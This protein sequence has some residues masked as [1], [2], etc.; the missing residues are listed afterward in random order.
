MSDT[1]N[2][3]DL[4]DPQVQE[5]WY[6][7]YDRLR[8]EA[9][10]CYMPEANMYVVS[11]YEDIHYI[12]RNPEIFTTQEGQL[13][14]DPLLPDADA[15]KIYKE[16]GFDRMFP[17]SCD[18][19]LHRCY[20]SLVEDAFS[21]NGIRKYE[22]FI[23]QRVDELIDQWIEKGEVEFISAFCDPLPQSVIAT[24]LGFPLEDLP[25]LADWSAAWVLPWSGELTKDTQLMVAQKGVEFQNY[26]VQAVRERRANPKDDLISHLANATYNNE[27]PLTE[28]EVISMIDHLFIGGNETT[29]FAIASGLWLLINNPL[30][31][32]Q[33]RGDRSLIKNMVEEILRMESPTQGM[34]RI[35][36]QETQLSGVTIPK[37][38]TVQL[39]FGAANRDPE[40][41]A[42]PAQM[43]VSRKNAGSH[44]AFSQATHSC[45]GAN[46]SRVEMVI[47]FE[48]LLGRLDDIQFA[49]AKN[50][51]S[52]MP[53][54]VLRA[55]NQ[56]HITFTTQHD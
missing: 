28:T 29:T 50:D 3:I 8:E 38:A 12:V 35:T 48:H 11:R 53:G 18:P 1:V 24:I 49:P 40:K 41:Y 33:V 9:P 20:R 26:I 44:M 42:C 5:D 37:G 21:R 47:A 36:S 56:L 15:R 7:T 55:L 31:M 30:Q 27:R 43:D 10:V 51:F 46:L 6:P 45:P 34:P 22:P 32:E 52:H 4:F 17:L 2:D 23:H 19:P 16:K 25:Q 54:F 13:N 14:R 39:R